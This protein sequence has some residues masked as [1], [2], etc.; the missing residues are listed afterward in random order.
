MGERNYEF[1]NRL[2]EVH[3]PN[4]RNTELLPE[5]DECRVDDEWQIVISENATQLVIHVAKDLQDYF[6][7]SMNCS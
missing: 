4:R 5:T 6:F 2:E 3:K 7:T 1:R